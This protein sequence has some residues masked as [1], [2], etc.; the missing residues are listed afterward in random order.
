MH[1]ALFD[2]TA[3]NRPLLGAHEQAERTRLPWSAPTDT[4]LKHNTP[5]NPRPGNH[6]GTE[7]TG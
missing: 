4:L 7:T 2:S 5:L 3:D 1:G 6:N